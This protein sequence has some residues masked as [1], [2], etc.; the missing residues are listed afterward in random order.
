MHA[1]RT[2]FGEAGSCTRCPLELVPKDKVQW[3]PLA[4]PARG[5][6]P[7]AE[8]CWDPWFEGLAVFGETAGIRGPKRKSRHRP[9]TCSSTCGSAR[10]HRRDVECD[11]TGLDRPS[12]NAVEPRLCSADTGMI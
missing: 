3:P 4:S 2:G 5:E 1:R 9:S 11:S 6:I 10:F 7:P 12:G 8:D